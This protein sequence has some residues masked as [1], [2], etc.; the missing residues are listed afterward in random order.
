M[1]VRRFTGFDALIAG[2]ADELAALIHTSIEARGA[3]R[4][5][6]SGGDTPRPLYERLATM[7]LQWDRIELWWGDDRC[8]PPENVDSNYRLV[9]VALLDRLGT[10]TIERVHRMMTEQPPVEAAEAYE[11]ELI[12]VLGVPPILDIALLGIGPDG[13]TASLFPGTAALTET[14]RWVVA[15]H[16]P[17][18]DTMRITMT[19]PTLRAA[20]HI[21]FLVAGSGKAA[22]LAAVLEGPRDPERYPA[23]LVAD[24]ET[25]VAWLVDDAAAAELETTP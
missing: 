11:R 13:H 20:R 22:A 9:K 23:Q 19:A 1:S 3:C 7:P 6:L 18:L 12:G 2:A 8:V 14:A 17:Q 10:N 5:A 21:R 25:D 15:N 24:A 16:V 4:I